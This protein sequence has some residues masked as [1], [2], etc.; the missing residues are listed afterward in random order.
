MSRLSRHTRTRYQNPTV[1]FFLRLL[2]GYNPYLHVFE[3][4]NNSILFTRT[5]TRTLTRVLT[6]TPNRF[7]GSCPDIY[8]DSRC[9]RWQCVATRWRLSQVVP[10]RL[11]A[12][13]RTTLWSSA[14]RN[15]RRM[16]SS[17]CSTPSSLHLSSPFSASLLIHFAFGPFTALDLLLCTLDVPLSFL[18]ASDPHPLTSCKCYLNVPPLRPLILFRTASNFMSR[19][20]LN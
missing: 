8:L 2:Y 18:E 20:F 9:G 3:L 17:S 14:A 1:F 11:C 19:L 5:P 15:N 16:S 7:S 6:L 13:G 4:R 10:T 12:Y